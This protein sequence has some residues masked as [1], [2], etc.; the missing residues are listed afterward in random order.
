VSPVPS[1]TVEPHGVTRLAPSP[2]GALHLGNARTFLLNWAVARALRWR[3]VLRIEDLDGPRIKPGAA[4]QITGTLRWLGMD[5]DEGPYVQSDDLSAY[6]ESMRA[7]CRAGLA[8]PSRL[9]RSDLLRHASTPDTSRPAAPADDDAVEGAS[10]PQAGSRETRFPAALRPAPGVFEFDPDF[11][12]VW[13]FRAPDGPDGIVEFEDVIAGPQRIYPA[14][15]VGDFILWTRLHAP[16]Y[17][18]SVVV[19]DHRQGV[20]RII[21]GDDLL[22]SAAR[23]RLLA[24]A[25]NLTPEP[26]Y[27]HLPLVVG[28]DGRRLAKRHGDT[29]LESYRQRGVP[30]EAIIGLVAWWSGLSDRREPL[31]IN[32]LVERIDPGDGA[33]GLGRMKRAPVV[34]GQEDERWLLEHSN[35]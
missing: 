5:W 2:T 9:T 32:E 8:F 22:D 13:R 17:Q 18:L 6:T 14:D 31:T 3:I 4:A 15:T 33:W 27:A 34:F 20:N 12:G 7:L 25:L 21:R 35:T 30:P 23:Q 11:D 1:Q 16:A 29:R 19:D 26:V 28:T 24:R 10:A